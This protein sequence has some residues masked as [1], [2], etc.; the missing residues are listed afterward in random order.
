M[1]W[2]TACPDW[3]ERIVAGRSLVP[4]DPLFPDE[5]ASALAVF[6]SLKVVDMPGQ[7]TFG[8]VC[9][10]W[11]FAFV[12]AIFGAYDADNARRLINEFFLLIAKKNGKSTIA[13]GIMVTALLRNWRFEAEL[14]ILAP[15]LEVANNSY[16]P[17][18]AMVRHD[19]ALQ[20]ILTVR[21]H[22]RL[23]EH[24]VTGATLQVVAAD[25]DTV[26]GKKA[27]FI[28]I[29]ELWL[30]GK[31]TGAAAM[32]D[33]ATGG[34]VARP[35]GFVISLS[36]HSDEPPEGVFKKKLH[37]FRDVRDGRIDDPKSFGLMFEYP[38]AMLEDK[39]FLD[40]STWHIPNP[41]M[42]YSVSAD[43]IADKLRKAEAGEGEDGDSQ[44]IWAKH[45]NVEIGL[46]LH[47]DRWNGAIY[48]EGAADKGITFDAL[49]ERSDV[50]VFGADGGGND[51]LFGLAACGR[52]A[53]T[54][55][56]LFWFRA[57]CKTD[58]LKQR[59]GIVTR[60]KDFEA[61]GSFAVCPDEDPGLDFR[62]AADYV[63]RAFEAGLLPEEA[64]VGVDSVGIAEFVDILVS[65]VGLTL[66]QI[67]AV[68]QGYRLSSAIWGMERKLKDGTIRHDGSALM[69]WCVGNAKIVQTGNAVQISK[70]V[71]GRAKIDPVI[72][73]L[74]AFQFMARHP[75]ASSHMATPWDIDPEFRMTA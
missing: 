26:G 35:E 3:Q 5:A 70:Q 50:I 48:W 31:R 60:L 39:R 12:A 20:D 37:Y 40:R 30:F 2:T 1:Q 13:A 66:K 61:E 68:P 29:D 42:G 56:W 34:L 54:R 44:A 63:R 19:P 59:K 22:K 25:S 27:G 16:K 49:L 15:T 74:N 36:T 75:V 14:L 62:Q 71:S 64:A 24:E 47:R 4:F 21:D 23:I 9:A 67:N 32:L 45:L 69:D 17:A 18:A 65:D 43:F 52:C 53:A 33:E 6:K 11:V 57:W 58:A 46:R 10:D 8:E 73:G 55:D 72:A 41:N 28:L 51:D 38:P 7:P